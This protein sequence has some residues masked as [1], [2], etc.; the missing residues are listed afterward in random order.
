[1]LQL[2]ALL[3]ANGI[4]QDVLTSQ[5]ALTHLSQHRT[6]TAPG[7]A[8]EQKCW[9][10]WWPGKRQPSP[11]PTTREEAT[12]A[13]RALDRLSLIDHAP[14]TSHHAVRIHQ[15]VQRAT[16]DTLDPGE[17]DQLAR[18]AADALTAAWP[19]VE[20]DTELTQALRANTDALTAHAEDALYRPDVHPVLY[21]TGESLGNF[22]QVTAAINHFRHLISA[23]QQCLGLDHLDTLAARSNLALWRGEAGNP[24]SAAAA[25]K[26]I[27]ADCLRVLGPDHPHTLAAKSNLAH[28]RGEAGNVAGAEATFKEVLADCLRVLGPDHRH[29]LS[30]RGELAHSRGGGEAG[31]VAGATAAFKGILADCLRVLGPRSSEAGNNSNSGSPPARCNFRSRSTSAT[32]LISPR[33]IA[34]RFGRGVFDSQSGTRLDPPKSARTRRCKAAGQASYR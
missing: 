32:V 13:L 22:G 12:G 25:F 19:D 29:T 31:D 16:R 11:A 24:D 8:P 27:L 3:D 21:R 2:A 1:M 18:T 5:P 7:Q 6:R 30:A 20:S 15:L 34:G 4:P 10:R 28:W 17:L 33:R 14:I 9:S 26:G 23:A